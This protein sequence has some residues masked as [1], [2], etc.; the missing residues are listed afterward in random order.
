MRTL[1][2]ATLF[3]VLA[4]AAGCLPSTGN[5]LD[6]QEKSLAQV[7][8]GTMREADMAGLVFATSVDARGFAAEQA[9]AEFPIRVDEFRDR[10]TVSLRCLA[11]FEAAIRFQGFEARKLVVRAENIRLTDNRGHTFQLRPAQPGY[12]VAAV[13]RVDPEQNAQYLE[14][15]NREYFLSLEINFTYEGQPL[16]AAWPKIYCAIDKNLASQ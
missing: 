12:G 5:P 15:N 9:L 13:F 11:G 14:F 1:R 10:A 2:F 16:K 7:G 3:S 8:A 6:W 4:A